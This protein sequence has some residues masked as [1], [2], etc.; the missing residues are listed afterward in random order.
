MWEFQLHKECGQEQQV[1]NHLYCLLTS[2]IVSFIWG[3]A[4]FGEA[5]KDVTLTMI[6]LAILFIGIAGISISG[7][8]LLADKK[9][10][11]CA[12]L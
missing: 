10:T 6:G 11:D 5:M 9:G 12:N 8:N 3:A 4:I 7:T 2:V 1:P